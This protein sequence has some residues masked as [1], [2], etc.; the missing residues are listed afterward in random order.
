MHVYYKLENTKYQIHRDRGPK[1]AVEYIL[2]QQ[3]KE[4]GLIF[5]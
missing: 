3:L 2:S 5:P 1:S 4:K